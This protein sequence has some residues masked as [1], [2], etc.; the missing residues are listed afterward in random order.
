MNPRGWEIR[1]IDRAGMGL[2]AF[3][4]FR[5]PVSAWTHLVWFLLSLPGTWLLWHRSQGDRSRQVSLL[6]YGLSIAS[7]SACSTLF[8]AVWLSPDRIAVL[9]RFDHA[10]IN[11]LIAGS[12]TPLAWN[13]LEG[14]LRRLVLATVWAAAGLNACWHI[15]GPI[16][17][18][19]AV[20]VYIWIGWSGSICYRDVA[21]ILTHR[22]SAPLLIG[23][24]I[25]STGAVFSVTGLPVLWPGV[26]EG[27]ELF[28]IFVMMGSFTHYRFMLGTIA[29]A[30]TTSRSRHR[31]HPAQ[32]GHHRP[33]R[34][35]IREGA[36]VL[37]RARVIAAGG[38][39]R[40]A[41]SPP[42]GW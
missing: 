16:P 39:D 38:V 33:N 23:G 2:M 26:F 18:G 29:L 10:G 42:D 41:M 34:C 8:H 3:F 12:Y 21:R 35:P 32:A 31:P 11:L 22:K 7:C 9:E 24:A 1:A 27:H 6:I 14:R 25:Y 28:H 37:P 36:G 17:L 4:V 15:A 19:Q 20:I 5:H 40:G 30:G 13:I